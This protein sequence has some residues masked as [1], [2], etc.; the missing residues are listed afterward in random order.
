MTPHKNKMRFMLG[1]QLLWLLMVLALGFWWG[2]LI[3]KYANQFPGLTLNELQRTHRMLYWE[4]ATFFLLLAASTAALFWYYWRDIKRSKSL[5]A[6]FASITHELRTP[7]TS[8]RLQAEALSEDEKNPALLKRLL[9][10]TL[11]LESQVERTL[12]LA[13]VEGGGRVFTQPV[14]IRPYIER[15]LDPYKNTLEIET[16]THDLTI[17][18]DPAALQVILKN[19]IE[20]SLRHVKQKKIQAK[21]VVKK[22]KEGVLLQYFDNGK[23]VQGDPKK[24]GQLFEKGPHSQGAGVGLYL[25]QVLMQRMGGQAIFNV[26][27]GL[28]AMLYFQEAPYGEA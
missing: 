18:A 13:R 4:G 24:L 9:E 2:S 26:N 7:L 5:Q 20:N 23:Y 11:R 28:E 14:L 15:M 12:E 1:V 25:I 10:D 8:I 21:V 6:F 19:L 3:L 22:S 16:D 17:K 27:P